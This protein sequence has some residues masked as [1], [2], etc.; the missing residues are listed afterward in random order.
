MFTERRLEYLC[1]TN[2]LTPDQLEAAQKKTLRMDRNLR[3]HYKNVLLV[4]AA[5]RIWHA[6]TIT[7]EEAVRAQNMYSLACQSWARMNTLL[8]PY[9]HLVEHILPQLLRLGPA[10]AFW[11]FALERNNGRLSKVNTNGHAGGELEATMMRSWVKNILLHNLVC[12]LLWR[13]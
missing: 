12:C 10:P 5:V 7:P 11:L 13:F 1:R 3:K 6:C 4:C 8:T 9:F 2:I